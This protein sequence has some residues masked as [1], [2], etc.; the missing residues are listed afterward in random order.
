MVDRFS[1]PWGPGAECDP[2]RRA[3]ASIQVILL[4]R[5]SFSADFICSPFSIS[6]ATITLPG[7]TAGGG[8]PMPI[9]KPLFFCPNCKA[10]YQVVKAEAGLETT[11]RE[12][13]LPGVQRAIPGTPRKVCP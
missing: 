2:L 11:D 13:Q 6:R 10:L 3:G 9:S 1:P 8:A 12:N 4:S 5:M 7:S